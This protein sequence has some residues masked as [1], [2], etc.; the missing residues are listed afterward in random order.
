MHGI[1]IP[2]LWSLRTKESQIWGLLELPILYL[3]DFFPDSLLSGHTSLT[4]Y[5]THID[6]LDISQH[7]L[8]TGFFLITHFFTANLFKKLILTLPFPLPFSVLSSHYFFHSLAYLVLLHSQDGIK[9]VILLNEPSQYRNFRSVTPCPAEIYF[10]LKVVVEFHSDW[11]EDRM[12]NDIQSRSKNRECSFRDLHAIVGIIF[13][14]TR[15]INNCSCYIRIWTCCYMP[16]IIALKRLKQ[17][18]CW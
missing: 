14:F 10:F 16:V 15:H 1:V 13:W 3:F 8:K 18:G 9:I 6:S 5:S 12:Q 17:E 7:S 11:K 2:G 4:V